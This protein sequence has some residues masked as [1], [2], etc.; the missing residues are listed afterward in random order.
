MQ[1]PSCVRH[2]DTV[3]ILHTSE[4]QGSHSSREP[5]SEFSPYL[6]VLGCCNI[7]ALNLQKIQLGWVLYSRQLPEEVGNRKL[8]QET[9]VT[10]LTFL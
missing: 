9:Q 3:C 10:H 8:G 2:A 6:S 7:V 4:F 5:G 1:A